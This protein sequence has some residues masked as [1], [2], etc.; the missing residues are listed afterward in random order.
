MVSFLCGCPNVSTY[1]AI[2]TLASILWLTVASLKD[3]LRR[4][5]GQILCVQVIFPWMVAV[6]LVV[7]FGRSLLQ[8]RYFAY[9]QIALIVIA[10]S[11]CSVYSQPRAICLW[12]AVCLTGLLDLIGAH[13]DPIRCDR[14]A[15]V[16]VYAGARCE[17]NDVIVVRY[18]AEVNQLTYHLAHSVAVKKPISVRCIFGLHPTNGHIVHIA[19]LSRSD[20]Y[21]LEG[22]YEKLPSH[23]W[24]VGDNPAI[25]SYIRM[26]GL[27]VS[28]LLLESTSGCSHV[29]ISRFEFDKAATEAIE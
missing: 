21:W 14:W 27:V 12:S 8:V 28:R 16:A 15:D 25:E 9:C 20:I 4:P 5:F 18:P 1:T 11:Q 19:S 29:D 22:P 13:G 24:S 2:I 6:L 3:N 7:F 26:R 17:P 23:F 10:A